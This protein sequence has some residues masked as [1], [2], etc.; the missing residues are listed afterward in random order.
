MNQEIL[1]NK[2]LEIQ[3]KKINDVYKL[4]MINFQ[5]FNN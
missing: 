5:K 2:V 1:V 3:L 4:N